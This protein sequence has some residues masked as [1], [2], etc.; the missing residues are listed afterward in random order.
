MKAV[1]LLCVAVAL[2]AAEHAMAAH[3]IQLFAFR[4]D[5]GIHLRW[6][7]NTDPDITGWLLERQ[8]HN[9]SWERLTPAPLP[10]V[11]SYK[12]MSAV[13]GR[14]KAMYFLTLF[15]VTDERDLNEADIRRTL[16]SPNVGLH[17]AFRAAAPEVAVISGEYYFDT[18]RIATPVS[19][20]IIPVSA[21]SVHEE[22]ATSVSVPSTQPRLPQPIDVQGSASD[23]GALLTWLRNSSND[24]A[25]AIVGYKVWR[26]ASESGP[27]ERADLLTSIPLFSAHDTRGLYSWADPSVA[28]GDT[29]YYYITNVHV[30]GVESSRSSIIRVV[31]TPAL[32]LV[33]P[34]NFHYVPFAA[35]VRLRWNW[36]GAYRPHTLILHRTSSD[37]DGWQEIWLKP[38]DTLYTDALMQPGY[39]YSY[40]I[41]VMVND[42]AAH[43]DTLTVSL[44]DNVPPLP[45]RITNVK[46]DTGKILLWWTRS[47]DSDA[48]GYVVYATSDTVRQNFLQLN[49]S[50]ISDTVYTHHVDKFTDHELFYKVVTVDAAGNNSQYSI[51]ISAKPLDI[52]PPAPAQ[53]QNFRFDNDVVAFSIL[54]S[55][56]ED[57]A[58]YTVF[59]RHN[60]A[61]WI[62][63]TKTSALEVTDKPT[64]PGTYEYRVAAADHAGNMSRLS[65][66][67]IAHKAA[68]LPSPKQLTVVAEAVCI[69]LQWQAVPNAAGYRITRIHPHTN[70]RTV[71]DNV[72]ASVQSYADRFADRLQQHTYEVTARTDNWEMGLPATILYTPPKE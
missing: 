13:V 15:G 38:A 40:F 59:R 10:F 48:V 49:S 42:T 18:L 25:N 67:R 4:T 28:V 11:L 66:S 71:I 8:V 3:D 31:G 9:A 6:I 72:E 68:T 32:S 5:S 26:S 30:T 45:P 57:V 14:Y 35:G 55:V 39:S 23:E 61:D 69:R 17:L 27:F 58:Q 33:V 1:V 43:T 21:R 34:N 37:G 2:V 16:T 7:G 60:A 56:S 46:S 29:V 36:E 44:P 22:L 12:E 62:T 20:R 19:Y 64:D 54:P 24:S 53:I 52:N 63:L 51:T 65:Q 50:P 41:S 47:P 70:Q